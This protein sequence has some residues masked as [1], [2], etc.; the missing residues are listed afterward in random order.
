MFVVASARD[1]ATIMNVK[2]KDTAMSADANS[3][4]KILMKKE[5]A[6]QIIEGAPKA[7]LEHE[8]EIEELAEIF[9]KEL[10]IAE[11]NNQE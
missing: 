6:D 2:R 5:V 4:R 8:K 3:T 11:D 10:G 1:A 7:L 9:R